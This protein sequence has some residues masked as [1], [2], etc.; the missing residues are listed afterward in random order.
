MCAARA[1]LC[2]GGVVLGRCCAQGTK[3]L[4]KLIPWDRFFGRRTPIVF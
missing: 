4:D 1:V 3:N 2:S